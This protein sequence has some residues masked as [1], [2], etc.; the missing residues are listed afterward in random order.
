MDFA[1]TDREVETTQ[2][3]VGPKLFVICSACSS[4]FGTG[5]AGLVGWSSGQAVLVGPNRDLLIWFF[6][7]VLGPLR[8]R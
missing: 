6:P 3:F 5:G 8:R 4:I 1:G 2:N 7:P